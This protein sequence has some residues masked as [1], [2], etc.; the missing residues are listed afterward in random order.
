[1]PIERGDLVCLVQG[2]HNPTLVRLHEDHCSIISAVMKA[3][4]EVHTNLIYAGRESTMWLDW[5]EFVQRIMCFP[6]DVLLVWHWES[7]H[8]QDKGIS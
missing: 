2:A 5:P 4:Q 3:P 8:E 6:A 7:T 1:M